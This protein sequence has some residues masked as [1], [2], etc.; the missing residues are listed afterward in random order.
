VRQATV[1]KGWAV[2]VGCLSFIWALF[3]LTILRDKYPYN[4]WALAFFTLSAAA[5]FGFLDN[6]FY[7]HANLQLLI[8][9]DG[10]LILMTFA[11]TRTV[12]PRTVALFDP[13]CNLPQEAKDDAYL[14]NYHLE[15][16]RDE[17]G[18]GPQLMSLV[19]SSVGSWCVVFAVSLVVQLR[20]G[21]QMGRFGSVHF[22][23][24]CLSVWF[25]Y[26]AK[27]IERRLSADDY[28]IGAVSFWADI[29]VCFF[30]C[31]CIALGS[32]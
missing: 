29:V 3:F 18:D 11:S 17:R 16:L 15:R 19:V 30:C 27:M 9:L 1:G 4:Y 23:V 28:M 32:T 31:V 13:W 7:S 21:A 6:N 5:F 12:S 2:A 26:D 24:M 14:R 25:G 10:V 22:F 20:E 8:Y